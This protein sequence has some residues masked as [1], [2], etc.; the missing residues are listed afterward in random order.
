VYAVGLGGGAVPPSDAHGR[1]QL[2]ISIQATAA[3]LARARCAFDQ[4][5]ELL[6]C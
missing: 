3:A 1:E 6:G 4:Q 5:R 2:G